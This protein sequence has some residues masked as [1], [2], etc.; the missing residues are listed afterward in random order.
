MRLLFS[1]LPGPVNIGSPH[2]L[3]ILELAEILRDLVGSE[4]R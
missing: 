1:D 4:P 2:E 3:T